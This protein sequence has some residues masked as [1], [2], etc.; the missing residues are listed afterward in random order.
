MQVTLRLSLPSMRVQS[1]GA[2]LPKGT[3]EIDISLQGFGHKVMI[4]GNVDS[5]L[6]P[7]ISV[8]CV[9]TEEN[10]RIKGRADICRRELLA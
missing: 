10:S 6:C 9:K 7:Q 1:H 8:N 3:G 2:S 4:S 5:Y